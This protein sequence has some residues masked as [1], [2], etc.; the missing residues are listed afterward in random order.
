MKKFVEFL[1][2]ACIA[3]MTWWQYGLHSDL[4]TVTWLLIAAGG[5]AAWLM[6][7]S[8]RVGYALGLLLGLGYQAELLVRFGG[9]QLDA[10][11][12]LLIWSTTLSAASAGL[13]W[14]TRDRKKAK[15]VYER[16]PSY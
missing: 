15:P 1:A 10:L 9:L 11:Q 4:P 14:T 5:V 6:C 2:T 12:P 7:R 3:L 13:L 16:H 8:L